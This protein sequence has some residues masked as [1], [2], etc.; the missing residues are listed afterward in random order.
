MLIDH[1]MDHRLKTFIVSAGLVDVIHWYLDNVREDWRTHP[2]F[3]TNGNSLKISP[4]GKIIGFEK[5]YILSASKRELLRSEH[6]D[7]RKNLILMGDLPTVSFL[8]V[9]KS[10]LFNFIGF[11]DG[12]CYPSC[13]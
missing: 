9:F 2:N 11:N 10:I 12:E 5:P 1:I 13:E 3:Y 4:E 7:H 8:L 6:H